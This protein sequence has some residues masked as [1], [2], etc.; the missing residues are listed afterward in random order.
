M[1]WVILNSVIS[2]AHLVPALSS[3]FGTRPIGDGVGRPDN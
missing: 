1:F 3:E 2:V